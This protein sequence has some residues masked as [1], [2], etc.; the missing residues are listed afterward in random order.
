MA[1]STYAVVGAYNRVSDL[2]PL[3]MCMCSPL[4]RELLADHAKESQA[5]RRLMDDN[6]G[7]C[8]T[9]VETG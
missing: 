2:I 3:N 9:L 7:I 1:V 5:I 8:Q 6:R 4:P